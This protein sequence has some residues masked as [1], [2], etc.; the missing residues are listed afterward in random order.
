MKK[1]VFFLSIIQLLFLGC[2]KD[3]L[4]EKRDIKLIVPTTLA[5]LRLLLNNGLTL[6]YDNIGIGEVAAGDYYINETFWNSVD[7]MQR[8]AYIWKDPFKG[9]A[10]VF[11]WNNS[12]NQIEVAN[13]ILG[14][15]SK[16]KPSIN[17]QEQWNDIKA[18]ALFIR[19]RAFFNLS[20]IFALP[21][22]P[23]NL[24]LPG[25]HLRLD[26][27]INTEVKRATIEK[28]YE[29]IIGDLIMA[30]SL[31]QVIPINKD[32][33]GKAAVHG[34]LAR[35]YLV[36]GDFESALENAEKC[37]S[38]PE[39]KLLDYS[40]LKSTDAFPFK[41]YNEEVI[42]SAT[43]AA[44]YGS[45]FSPNGKIVPELYH[46]YE[47]NDLRKSLFYRINAVDSSYSFRGMYLGLRGIFSGIATDEIYLIKSECEARSGNISSA[48]KTLNELL[49]TRYAK[50]SFN[51]LQASTKSEALDLILMERRKELVLRGLRWTDIRRLSLDDG[52]KIALSRTIEGIEHKLP[53]G[54]KRYAF[55]IP[56]YVTEKYGIEQ[57][58]GWQDVIK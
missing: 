6:P 32:N 52:H 50:D 19:A 55:P 46:S 49:I 39:V 21:Y 45:F 4:D 10:T 26:P 2:S 31:A 51:E 47:S 43:M 13:V 33:I 54:D 22:S 36:M 3:W 53:V 12:Y 1:I 56:D 57:N 24:N 18:S 44:N 30:A 16:L 11:E 7:E 23:A 35:V 14:A 5:D 9:R 58:P 15:L 29:Q 27:D 20:S 8:F 41:R 34:Q 48:M 42:L 28:T 38:Y 25:V 40:T 37:L 17:E